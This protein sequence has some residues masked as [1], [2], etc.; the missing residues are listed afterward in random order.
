MSCWVCFRD[1]VPKAKRSAIESAVPE[2]FA[3]GSS[4][5]DRVLEFG[6][7]DD[8]LQ[9]TVRGVYEHVVDR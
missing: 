2:S 8:S 3:V 7:D 4:G 9:W 5:S 1:A 6:N